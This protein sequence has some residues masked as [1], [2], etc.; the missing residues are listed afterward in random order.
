MIKMQTRLSRSVGVAVSAGVDSMA[1]LDFLRRRH[2]VTIYHFNHGTQYG[3]RASEFVS[4]YCSDHQLELKT[5]KITAAK[6]TNESW[7]EFWRNQR[8]NWFKTHAQEIVLGH[9]LDDCVETYLFN[10]CHGKN[11]TIPYRHS[12]CIRPFR[13]T[14][15]KDLISWANKN[16]VPWIN[17]PSNESCDFIRNHIRMKLMPEVLIVNPG[18]KK[19]VKKQIL[20]ED[21]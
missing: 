7:E 6:P 17:D 9:H 2:I 20:Q 3:D 11:H 12:N 18:V 14:E 21:V 15:K 13:L 8:Y 1:I 19:V 5:A 10:M 4:D 16:N